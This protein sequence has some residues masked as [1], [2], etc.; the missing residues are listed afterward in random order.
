MLIVPAQPISITL[1]S[2]VDA[3]LLCQ[4]SEWARMQF[5]APVLNGDTFIGF[6]V[7]P[8]NPGSGGSPNNAIKLLQKAPYD[9]VLPPGTRVFILAVDNGTQTTVRFDAFLGPI[10]DA[11]VV[12]ALE[13]L[14]QLQATGV[15]P[16]IPPKLEKTI[17]KGIYDHIQVQ[18]PR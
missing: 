14:T 5:N 4:T 13:A 15:Q 2:Q 9:W 3:V 8:A 11:P 17:R 10:P 12:M 18:R 6:G 1:E 16:V 7:G